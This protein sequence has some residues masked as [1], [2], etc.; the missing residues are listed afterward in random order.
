VTLAGWVRVTLVE[1]EKW[2]GRNRIRWMVCRGERFFFFARLRF[3]SRSSSTKEKMLFCCATNA[4]KKRNRESKKKQSCKRV[5]RPKEQT[6]GRPKKATHCAGSQKIMGGGMG[7]KETFPLLLKRL[8]SGR[9]SQ[10]VWTCRLVKK[11]SSPLS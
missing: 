4:L 1:D 3:G 7:M 9:F 6:F 10:T 2:I 5:S 11:A 8:E